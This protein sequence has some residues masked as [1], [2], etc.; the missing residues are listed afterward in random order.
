MTRILE[1][2]AAA[3]QTYGFNH[4]EILRISIK[5]LRTPD[6]LQLT[7]AQMLEAIK[8]GVLFETKHRRRA[9]PGF[10]CSETPGQSRGKT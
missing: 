3:L 5:D 6:T 9:S 4:E 2:N 7:A 10:A 8:E 1:A